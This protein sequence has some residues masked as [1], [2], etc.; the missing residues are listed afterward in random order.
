MTK[1]LLKNGQVGC[2]LGVYDA[3]VLIE[4][5]KI[6]NTFDWG[7]KH[8]VDETIDCKGKIILPGLI[9]VH[10][11]LREPGQKYK[12]DWTTG[13]KA[14][15]AGG[16][17]TICDMPNNVPPILT[18]KDLEEKRKLVAKKAYCNYGLYMGFD[19]KNISEINKAEN[20]PAVK[21][22]VANSTGNMGVGTETIAELF[23][24]CNKF[25][26]AHAEDEGMI[27][28]K[29]LEYLAEYGARIDDDGKLIVPKEAV[30][31]PSVH[32]KIRSAD[33]AVSAV[34]FLCELAK[35][36]GKR[37]HV[38]HVSSDQELT[39]LLEYQN[40]DEAGQPRITCEVAPHHLLL[41]DD[42]YATFGNLIKVNP[43]VRSKMDLFTMWKALKFGEVHIIATDH[44]PHTLV[45]KEQ[46]YMDVPSGIPELDTL[47]P[48]LLNAVND[49]GLEMKEVVKLCCESPAKI[50][51]MKNKGQVE[52]GFDADL[53]VVDM[54]KMFEVKNEKLFT[55]CKW[56]PYAGSTF[57]GCPIMT[58]VNGEL[59]YKNGKIVGKKVGKEVEF[60]PVK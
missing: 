21:V 54:E 32:S 36:N 13:T 53:V 35:E 1:I 17:T 20:I 16:V 38:A 52:A 19:G 27:K 34:K 58:F 10:V 12:E 33:C 49:G 47:L 44:A 39:M 14:A 57:K 29:A 37:L 56:S 31:D 46:E 4:D 8:E 45:E 22:Y 48:I 5:G 23:K 15:V 24:K 51:G 6:V 60:E 41:S 55:K 50:F 2:A 18:V 3:D 42:D 26:V 59:V 25:I 7:Q 11:H 40:L 28:E 30:I 43:P 9:D